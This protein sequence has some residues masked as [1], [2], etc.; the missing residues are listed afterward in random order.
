MAFISFFI[1]NFFASVYQGVNGFGFFLVAA[2]LA[3]LFLDKFTVVIS[4]TIIS[5]LLNS[6]LIRKIH[7]PI[8][9]NLLF[10]LLL[11]SLVGMPF[12][13]WLLTSASIEIIK[14]IAGSLA[15]I[16][17]FLIVF[18]K[19]A[20]HANKLTTILAGVVSG[21]L[22]TSIGMSGPPVV[23]L[24]AGSGKEKNDM[25]KT[26]VTYFLF[27]NFISL[28]FFFSS[29]EFTWAHTTISI[30]ALPFCFLGAYIGNKISHKLSQKTYKILALV[31][32]VITGLISIYSG[33]TS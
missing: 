14:I 5:V 4:L 24:L 28:P 21:V 17:T 15:I 3:L 27:L 11:A 8:H 23:L 13:L 29:G 30:F 10:P 20:M 31:T 32:V 2:P 16:F 7:H 25:R 22:Q 1:I 26:L 9:W 12:G 19:S 18:Q 33:L 6:F